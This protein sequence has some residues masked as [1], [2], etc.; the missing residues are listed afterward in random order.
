MK[1]IFYQEIRKSAQ[2]WS[3]SI[4][5]KTWEG[6]SK[7]CIF[8]NHLSVARPSCSRFAKRHSSVT[9][10]EMR[11]TPS[12]S[13][14]YTLGVEFLAVI[15]ST[16]VVILFCV[17]CQSELFQQ[18]ICMNFENKDKIRKNIKKYNKIC[19]C[20]NTVWYKNIN[21]RNRTCSYTVKKNF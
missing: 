11:L 1:E 15:L 17:I 14:S 4:F 7:C 13:I 20:I 10:V 12:E 16:C 6:K 9:G 18:D 8:P 2:A 21:R 5:H 3:L 19:I